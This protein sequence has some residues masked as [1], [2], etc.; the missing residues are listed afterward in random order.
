MASIRE[1]IHTYGLHPHQELI[2]FGSSSLHLVAGK[3]YPQAGDILGIKSRKPVDGAFMR[4]FGAFLGIRLLHKYADGK[5]PILLLIP[6]PDG[7]STN[8]ASLGQIAEH[9]STIQI[10]LLNC[11]T[12][13]MSGKSLFINGFFWTFFDQQLARAWSLRKLMMVQDV[14][15]MAI[16]PDGASWVF[17]AVQRWW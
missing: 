11:T 5:R 9:L 8:T 14:H 4:D 1:V 15:S 13:I 2:G 16:L 12:K 3:T 10:T 7:I 6:T 17:Y